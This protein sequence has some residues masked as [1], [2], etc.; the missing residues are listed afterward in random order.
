[1]GPYGCQWHEELICPVGITQRLPAVNAF[2]IAKSLH[3]CRL[4]FEAALGKMAR[5]A[6]V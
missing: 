1:M 4:P 6:E 2:E 5:L 3:A